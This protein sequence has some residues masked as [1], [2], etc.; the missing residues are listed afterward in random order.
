MEV[1]IDKGS[2][3][4]RTYEAVWFAEDDIF[5]KVNYYKMNTDGVTYSLFET[6]LKLGETDSTVQIEDLIKVYE[7]FT[8]E[9]GVFAPESLVNPKTYDNEATVLGDKSTVINMYYERNKY[10]V[11]LE[12]DEGA[13]E[14]LGMGTYFFEEAV[15]LS[16]RMLPGYS[17]VY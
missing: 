14:V 10:E 15:S 5:Y 16:A 2:I 8:F 6:N 3:D 11:T 9:G 17:F 4:N 13:E 12:K 1:T 7:G